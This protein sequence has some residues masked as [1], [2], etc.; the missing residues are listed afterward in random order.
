MQSNALTP[1]AEFL[2]ILLEGNPTVATEEVSCL[3]QRRYPQLIIAAHK[4]AGG[5]TVPLAQGYAWTPTHNF[6]CSAVP[7]KAIEKTGTIPAW[8]TAPANILPTPDWSPVTGNWAYPST[9]MHNRR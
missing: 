1:P 3:A 9:V 4:T 6:H 7:G 2:A 8:A 5:S